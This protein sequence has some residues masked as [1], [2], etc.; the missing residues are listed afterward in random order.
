MRLMCRAL[1]RGGDVGVRALGPERKMPGS[2]FR[3]GKKL[4]QPAVQCAAL[5]HG[6]F[7]VDAG[8]EQRVGE[9]DVLPVQLDDVPLD[10]G[11]EPVSG[12]STDGLAH[13]LEGG[14]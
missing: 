10:G 2:L 8:G 7:G 5:G 13:Q 12:A 14:I 4:C 11:R 6:G 3:V 1:E 9:T